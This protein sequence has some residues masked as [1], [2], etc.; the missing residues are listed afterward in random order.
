MELSLLLEEE[1][2]SSKINKFIAELIKERNKFIQYAKE[3]RKAGISN[4]YGKETVEEFFKR[5]NELK[6]VAT[7]FEKENNK[8]NIELLKSTHK[9][10]LDYIRKNNLMKV[11]GKVSRVALAIASSLFTGFF[12]VPEYVVKGMSK[13]YHLRR[14]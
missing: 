1:K 4:E 5:V 7:E 6:Q 9:K 10:T 11:I 2:I 13:A 14:K 12:F 3:D 8:E